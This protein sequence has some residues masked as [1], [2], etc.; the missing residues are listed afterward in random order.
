ML[1]VASRGAGLFDI[2]PAP[3][4]FGED[5]RVWNRTMQVARE[6]NVTCEVHNA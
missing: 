1:G 2:P 6:I 4:A 5:E 3:P